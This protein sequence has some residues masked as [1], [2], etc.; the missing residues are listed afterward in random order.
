[1]KLKIFCMKNVNISFTSHLH[2]MGSFFPLHKVE[3]LVLRAK[4]AIDHPNDGLYV[5]N[6][7]ESLLITF[8]TQ[9]WYIDGILLSNTL[10]SLVDVASGYVY[11]KAS[12]K[13]D[14]HHIITKIV[15]S[16]TQRYL[17][18]K[19]QDLEFQLCL[20]KTHLTPE[21]IQVKY[22]RLGGPLSYT[23]MIILYKLLTHVIPF[24]E[25]SELM[26]L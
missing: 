19:H 10:L 13:S 23:K 14:R 3:K 24:Y 7:D 6:A 18:A 15:Q 11:Y 1:M 9:K 16:E 2:K 4:G 20:T 5:L 17:V 21:P 22:R 25:I 12:F 26:L 8:C